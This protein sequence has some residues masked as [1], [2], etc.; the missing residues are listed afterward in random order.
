MPDFGLEINI[1][2]KKS[3]V[4][5]MSLVPAGNKTLNYDI[6]KDESQP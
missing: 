4:Y 3:V 5:F 2:V 1:L 6:L